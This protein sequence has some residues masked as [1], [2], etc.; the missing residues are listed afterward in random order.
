MKT[1]VN[2]HK[3]LRHV[4]VNSIPDIIQDGILYISIEYSTIIHKCCCGCGG[5]VVT[6]LSPIDWK[7]TYDGRT[8]SLFPSV[9]NWSFECQSHYWITNDQVIWA[10]QWSKEE[11]NE[12]RNQEEFV[13]SHAYNANGDDTENHKEINATHCSPIKRD[14]KKHTIIGWLLSIFKRN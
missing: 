12:C 1:K 6:R 7:M 13:R 9:G 11:I 4:F 3:Y 14:D 8:I 10:K 2:R 5:E